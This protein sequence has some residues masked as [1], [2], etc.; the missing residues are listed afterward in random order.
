M[1]YNTRHE[2]A[3]DPKLTAMK[4][5]PDDHVPFLVF[6]CIH[7]N[8]SSR[9]KGGRKQLPLSLFLTPFAPRWARDRLSSILAPHPSPRAASNT[10]SNNPK[11]APL[12]IYCFVHK[13]V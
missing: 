4:C 2:A 11:M 13:L 8:A 7:H 12:Y 3:S 9:D 5:Y 6:Q 10:A 1:S